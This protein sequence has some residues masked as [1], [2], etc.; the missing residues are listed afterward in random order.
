M[1]MA[2]TTKFRELNEVWNIYFFCFKYNVYPTERDWDWAK[3]GDN[4][5]RINHFQNPRLERYIIR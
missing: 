4:D 1:R 2:M 5:K 3:A